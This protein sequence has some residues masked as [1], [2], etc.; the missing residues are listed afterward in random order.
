MYVSDTTLFNGICERYRLNC[1][2]PNMCTRTDCLNI[3]LLTA[4]GNYL[5]V[6]NKV[7]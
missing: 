6:I 4:F 5:F 2:V 7:F 1:V 3:D